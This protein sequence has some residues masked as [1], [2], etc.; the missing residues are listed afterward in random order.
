MLLALGD[1]TFKIQYINILF[2]K[3]GANFCT[4]SWKTTHYQYHFVTSEGCRFKLNSENYEHFALKT[5]G[6]TRQ[7]VPVLRKSKLSEDFF[8]YKNEKV[9]LQNHYNPDNFQL[10]YLLFHQLLEIKAST[11][12]PQVN[13]I[14]LTAVCGHLTESRWEMSQY[15]K[16]LNQKLILKWTA[17]IQLF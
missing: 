8:T 9:H 1:I 12:Q 15:A 7:T 13:F 2:L 11:G 4:F 6:C 16:C 17:S 5:S 3:R 14:T 10:R